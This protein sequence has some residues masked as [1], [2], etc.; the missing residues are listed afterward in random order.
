VPESIRV[1]RHYMVADVRFKLRYGSSY[2]PYDTNWRAFIEPETGAVL[3]LRRSSAVS[4]RSGARWMW[5]ASRYGWCG[6]AWLEGLLR[7]ADHNRSAEEWEQRPD[8]APEVVELG[9]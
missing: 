6:L 8:T 7:L 5:W 3:L 9:R 2:E 1:G 4:Q